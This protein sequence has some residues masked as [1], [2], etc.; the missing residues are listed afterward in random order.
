MIEETKASTYA[1]D[2]F[3][4]H[5]SEDTAWCEKLANKLQEFGLKVWFDKWKLMPGSN[6]E[7]TIPQV[8]QLKVFLCHSSE[9]KPAVRQLYRQL[10]NESVDPW[11]DEEKLLPGQDWQF[12]IWKAVRT[13]DIVIVCLSRRSITKEGFVQ[14]EIKYPANFE[15]SFSS[16]YLEK[17]TSEINPRIRH[18]QFFLL[19]SV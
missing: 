4:S 1:Y 19:F 17:L 15:K 11:L 16:R 14:K 12:E 9:D 6:G 7:S 10:L 13:S 2:V 5:A 3:I 18:S 8:R